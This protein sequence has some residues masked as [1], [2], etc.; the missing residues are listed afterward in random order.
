MPTK[1]ER[2]S[3]MA[4][5]LSRFDRP[6]RK[7]CRPEIK[8]ALELADRPGT[9]DLRIT[10]IKDYR[11]RVYE[12]LGYHPGLL[13]AKKM[14]DAALGRP[15]STFYRPPIDLAP[16]DAQTIWTKHGSV[17]VRVYEDRTEVYVNSDTYKSNTKV[18]LR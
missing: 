2:L 9:A 4:E 7:G 10:G 6:T 5:V 18:E 14:M 11:E 16:L 17:N 3:Q 13:E 1:Q 8:V 15:Q 12:E